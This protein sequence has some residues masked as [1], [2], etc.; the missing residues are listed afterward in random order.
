[1][2]VYERSHFIVGS[3]TKDG[4]YKSCIICG[5]THL[6]TFDFFKKHG[7]RKDGSYGTDSKCLNC[8]KKYKAEEYLKN[9]ETYDVYKVNNKEKIKESKSSYKKLHQEEMRKYNTVYLKSYYIKNKK[10]LNDINNK[11]Y[12]ENAETLREK[13]KEYYSNNKGKWLLDGRRFRKINTE[14]CRTYSQNYRAKVRKNICD[15]TLDQWVKCLEYFNYCDAYTGLPL[16]KV[17]QDHIVPVSKGG[18]TTRSN[19]IPCERNVNSSKRDSSMEVWYRKQQFFNE[20]RL[21]K[22]QKYLAV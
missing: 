21:G 4:K 8:L 13:R 17:S 9:K 19:I 3:G 20:D 6:N 15:L 7:K 22:I 2:L 10:K 14:R 16:T 18:G 1:M 12:F 5:E 11:Y